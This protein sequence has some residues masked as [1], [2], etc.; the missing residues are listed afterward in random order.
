M[1]ILIQVA[2]FLDPN[3]N[4]RVRKRPYELEAAINLL[5]IEIERDVQ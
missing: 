3:E 2:A 4:R 5:K 1:Y